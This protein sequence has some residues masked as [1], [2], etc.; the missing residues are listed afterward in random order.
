MGS[1]C[2]FILCNAMYNFMKSFF[3]RLVMIV[4]QMGNSN[5]IWPSQMIIKYT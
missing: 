4:N 5:V 2:G 1:Q 3:E